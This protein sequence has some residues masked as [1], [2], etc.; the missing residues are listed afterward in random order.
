[1]EITE[2]SQIDPEYKRR[3][4][5]RCGE[6]GVRQLPDDEYWKLSEWYKQ[7]HMRFVNEYKKEE[8]KEKQAEQRV[9]RAIR[10]GKKIIADADRVCRDCGDPLTKKPGRGRWPVR[11]EECKNG[12]N[13]S[14]TIDETQADKVEW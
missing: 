13:D 8:E 14:P 6:L 11:C 12:T 1:M 5:E 9:N 3:Y 7:Q 4:R 2:R 10:E